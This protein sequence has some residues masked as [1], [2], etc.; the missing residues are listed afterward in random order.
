[1]NPRRH[2]TGEPLNIG[3]QRRVKRYV[4]GRV[5]ADDVHHRRISALCVVKIGDA[6]CKAR[7]KMEQC[8]RWLVRHAG[9]TV[10]GARNNAFEK[11]ENA[12]HLR[13]A[14]ECRHKVHF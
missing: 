1:M 9:V 13:L 10:R 8:G 7:S 14:V 12:S 3:G 2:G 5:L 11:S 6:V 4:I